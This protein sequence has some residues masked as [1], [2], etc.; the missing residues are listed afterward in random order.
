MFLLKLKFLIFLF[1]NVYNVLG[2]T[3]FISKGQRAELFEIMDNEVPVFRIKLPKNEVFMLKRAASHTQSLDFF[4]NK[5]KTIIETIN[6][7]NFNEMYPEYD[8]NEI[9]PEL[10]INTKGFP[11]IDYTKFVVSF[12]DYLSL[13]EN[14]YQTNVILFNIFNNNPYLNLIKVF[15]TLSNLNMPTK[16][17]EDIWEYMIDF[18]EGNVYV[19]EDGNYKLID[20]DNI[21]NENF[22]SNEN[23]SGENSIEDLNNHNIINYNE[24]D[25]NENKIENYGNDIDGNK[26]IENEINNIDNEYEDNEYD[27]NEYDNNEI[28]NENNNNENDDNENGDDENDDNENDDNEIDD[29]NEDEDE[30]TYKRLTEFK[31]KNGTLTVKFKR[32]KKTFKKITFSLSGHYSRRFSKPN[33]NLKIRGGEELFGR[34]QFKLRGDALDPSAMRTKLMCDI[35]NRLGLPSIAANYALLYINDEFMGLYILTDAFKQSW[36]EYVYGEK[37]TSSLYK[38]EYCDLTYEKRRGFKNENKEATDKDKRELYQFLKTM[39]KAKSAADVAS[40]FDINQFYKEI[41][42]EFLTNGIDHFKNFHNYF[43]YKNPHNQKWIYLSYDFDL[44]FGSI[45]DTLSKIVTSSFDKYLKKPIIKNLIANNYYEFS[46]TLEEIIFKVFNPAILFPHIDEIK[47][48]IRPYVKKDKIPNSDG[49]YP[50]RINIKDKT[51]YTME[52]WESSTEFDES[53][54]GLKQYILLRYR[55]IC[56]EFCIRCDPFYF[57]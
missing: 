50:G 55:Y 10:H 38:C 13:T 18:G 1:Y 51:F 12:K 34:R 8:F 21:P 5:I 42:I 25:N 39:T 41:S 2:V 48:F 54:M 4:N 44:D 19:D 22:D 17:N 14:E 46:E 28:D 16:L 33:F 6:S 40:I 23:K 35:H 32:H 20:Y 30:K 43:I 45:E 29:K 52:Q 26:Y 56:K 37:N 47:S 27:D 36:I 7:E 57:Y 9:L 3:S 11:N 15:Y 24:I 31:T 53:L 49:N